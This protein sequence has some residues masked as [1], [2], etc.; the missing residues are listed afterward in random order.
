MTRVLG[1]VL[2]GQGIA[3]AYD[4]LVEDRVIHD[5]LGENLIAAFW[6]AGTASAVDASFIPDGR[7][8]GT[9]GVFLRTVGNLVLT[10]TANE[11]G[12]F[13]DTETGSTWDILGQAI[14]GP[15]TGKSLSPMPHHDTFW[16]A[17]AAFVPEGA[18]TE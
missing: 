9:T 13:R 10:F 4:R 17:W 14:D 5:I 11:D 12:T 7:D 15:L 16:F 1:V 3:F 18:L 8:V 2:D 6:K